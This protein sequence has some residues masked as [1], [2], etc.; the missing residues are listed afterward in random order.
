MNKFCILGN[1]VAT[2]RRPEESPMAGWGQY[3]Q[4]F[5]GPGY[6]VKNYARDAM[7]LRSYFTGRFVKLLNLLEPGDFVAIDFGAVEQRLNVAL[8]FH[9]P[10]E[11]KE[12]LKLYV[13]AIRGEGAIPL[14]LTPAARCVFDVHGN[15]V[16]THGGY[17]QYAREAAAEAGAALIDLNLI[18]TRLLQQLGCSRA[19]G[20][21]RWEDAGAHPNHPEGIIDSAHFNDLGAR[22]VAR[23]FAEALQ[24]TPG[25][26][27]G[28]VDP[29]RLAPGH[30]PPLLPEFTVQHPEGALAEQHR[31][32]APPVVSSP[33]HGQMVSAYPKFTGQ[34]DPGTSYLLFFDGAGEYV[35]GTSVN[36]EGTWLWRRVVGWPAGEHV[37]QAVGLHDHG[38]SP[39]S[40]VAFVVRDQVEAPVVLGPKEGV[41][42]GPRPKF[43]GTAAQGVRKVVVLESG[44]L[45]A[46]APVK[47]DGTWSLRHPH[48]W[49]P[50]VHHL[51]FVSVFSALRSDPAGLTIKVHGIPQ[52]NW[53]SGSAGARRDC[54]SACEHLP[55]E[56]S[57]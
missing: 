22:E 57:W 47:D 8:R 35:G 54:G 56:P 10:R 5:L 41:W 32:G 30:Y 6:E 3:V 48:D 42:S 40:A 55:H 45:I 37:L 25:I 2:S 20:L 44:R 17:P 34:A 33:A 51:E 16:D 27:P 14:V 24:G 12:Y 52:D 39:V 26:A 19:R 9:G 7:T 29:A 4:E 21:F 46:E 15:V 53:L 13:E 23:L 49:E 1:S 28:V 50:G 11:F 36:A 43:S 18:T 38:M 31:T